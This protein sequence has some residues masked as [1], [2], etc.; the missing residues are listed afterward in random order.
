MIPTHEQ[1]KKLWDKYEF[2]E[3]KR[4]HVSLVARVAMWMAKKLEVCGSWFVVNKDLLEA[5][6]LLHDIDKKIPR[7]PGERHPQTGVR[8]LNLEGFDEVSELIK[9]HSVQNILDVEKKPNS[10]EEKILFLADKMV[11]YE[12]ITVDKRFKLWE[13]ED[14]PKEQ[15]EMLVRAYPKVKELERE[16]F[17]FLRVDPVDVAILV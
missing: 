2:P 5:G 10:W 9:N 17:G 4:L 8:I 11:K 6:A 7:L 16:I 15:M 12:I 14:L 3:Q 1:I 13:A